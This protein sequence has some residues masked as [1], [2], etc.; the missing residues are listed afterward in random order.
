VELTIT[1][2]QGQIR[3]RYDYYS[4]GLA[5][6]QPVNPY[7]NTYGLKE[8]QMQEWGDK[9]IELYQFE[10][11]MYDPVLGRW[12]APDPLAQFH[13]PYLANHNNPAN[14]TDPDGRFSFRIG[15]LT[16]Q[17]SL[18]AGISFTG[19]EIFTHLNGLTAG[20]TMSGAQFAAGAIGTAVGVLTVGMAIGAC[21][22]GYAD[23]MDAS[24]TGVVDEGMGKALANSLAAK[25][26]LQFI[27]VNT[28][29]SADHQNC[30]K[31]DQ[32]EATSDEKTHVNEPE[33]C[34][35]NPCHPIVLI[36]F[37][38]VQNGDDPSYTNGLAG[39]VAIA[40]DGVVFSFERS[41]KWAEPK[42]I[43]EYLEYEKENRWIVGLEVDVDKELIKEYFIFD[44]P[45]KDRAKDGEYNIQTNSCVTNIMEAL[46]IGG[47]QINE[48]NGVVTPIE[49]GRELVDSSY[50]IWAPY[51][52]QSLSGEGM[53]ARTIYGLAE[54]FELQQTLSGYPMNSVDLIENKR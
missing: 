14:F 9:G 32:F 24:V 1:H 21:V 44:G 28:L 30:S 51:I 23:L 31:L 20:S 10:A 15:D 42:D 50:F 33:P 25:G 8:W 2:K 11:R 16:V 19:V 38:T 53:I 7:D 34:I 46:S 29:S 5:W 6:Q 47:M 35:P 54:L 26:E 3:A 52:Y 45:L 37:P 39:H 4:Y 27:G 13:S 48:H 49:L 36:S 41:G 18:Q 22:E 43:I 17:A 40:I 12:H